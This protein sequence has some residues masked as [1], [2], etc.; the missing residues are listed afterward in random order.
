MKKVYKLVEWYPNVGLKIGD[1]VKSDSCG[2]YISNRP[3]CIFQ[4][5]EV[6]GNKFWQEVKEFLFKTFDEVEIYVGNDYWVYDENMRLHNVHVVP[7]ASSTHKGNG[8][9]RKYFS[10]KEAA[11]EHRLY[12]K[13]C[14][15]MMDCLKWASFN[16]GARDHLDIEKLKEL[17][18]TKII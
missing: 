15:T 4:Q 7:R 9:G 5:D 18:K 12:N 8:T 6:E 2:Q 13:P 14:F 1:L 3:F 10:T 16:E 11:E 17:A